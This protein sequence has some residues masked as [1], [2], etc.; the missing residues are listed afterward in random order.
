MWIVPE[1]GP[2]FEMASNPHR[3]SGQVSKWLIVVI[4]KIKYLVIMLYITVVLKF[5]KHSH[6]DL[7]TCRFFAGS[8]MKPSGSLESEFLSNAQK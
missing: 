2:V 4:K 1:C 5:P 7:K 8:F 3:V 6:N